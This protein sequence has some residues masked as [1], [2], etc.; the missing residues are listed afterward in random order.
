MVHFHISKVFVIDYGL[1]TQGTG[2]AACLTNSAM[3]IIVVIYA[4]CLEEV[5]KMNEGINWFGQVLKWQGLKEYV[6]IAIPMM[7]M[8]ISEW[9]AYEFITVMT[10]Y[11][12]VKA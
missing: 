4:N 3:L 7:L 11:V 5:Q 8:L 1:G 12:G 10:G 6:E 9:W 2:Y